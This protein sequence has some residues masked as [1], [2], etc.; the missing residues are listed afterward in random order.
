LPPG[1]GGPGGVAF[2]G[3][4]GGQPVMMNHLL[5]GGARKKKEDASVCVCV[6][7]WKSVIWVLTVNSK[8]QINRTP[9]V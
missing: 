1:Q 4:M 5:F 8:P 7:L 2:G 6:C 3:G 9:V